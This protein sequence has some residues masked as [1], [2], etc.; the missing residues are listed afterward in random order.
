MFIRLRRTA[1][2]NNS[3]QRPDARAVDL[4]E[5]KHT[6]GRK[7]TR[8]LVQEHS[9]LQPKTRSPRHH[10]TFQGPHRETCMPTAKPTLPTKAASAAPW[11]EGPPPQ[12]RTALP[13][14]PG[15]WGLRGAAPGGSRAAPRSG[16][17]TTGE[18]AAR[19]GRGSHC[20]EGGRGG[21]LGRAWSLKDVAAPRVGWWLRRPAAP[22]HRSPDAFHLAS[23]A[24]D[25]ARPPALS[26][27]PSRGGRRRARQTRRSAGPPAPPPAPAP[28]SASP[29]PR[30][31]PARRPRSQGGRRR[32][33][34]GARRVPTSM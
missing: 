32:L 1:I 22:G 27:A 9:H 5:G 19:T 24:A 12:A 14:Q 34:S 26:T 6:G 28:S 33:H 17:A 11:W 18:V 13:P 30:R 16:A 31:P 25:A 29:G 3:S 10:R 2:S 15:G 7:H 20:P 21:H 4:F 23:A 8:R